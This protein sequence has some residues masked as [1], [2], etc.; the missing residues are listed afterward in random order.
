MK[1][2]SEIKLMTFMKIIK[3][4]ESLV[5]FLISNDASYLFSE[6]HLIIMLI[7]KVCVRT[8]KF[9]INFAINF[10]YCQYGY[11]TFNFSNVK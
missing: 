6:L 7:N 8:A 2:N 3:T 4:I 5:K 11:L 1:V 9:K 10:N